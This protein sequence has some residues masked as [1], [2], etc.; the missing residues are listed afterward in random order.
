MIPKLKDL[1]Y[2]DKN[3]SK[4]LL[5]ANIVWDRGGNLT[6]YTEYKPILYRKDGMDKTNRKYLFDRVYLKKIA[7][8]IYDLI[9]Y[10]KEF[11]NWRVVSI[12]NGSETANKPPVFKLHHVRITRSGMYLKTPEFVTVFMA[13]QLPA[14]F[15]GYL[16]LA[17]K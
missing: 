4:V 10:T 6:G 12:K 13:G 1:K 5:D 11:K 17:K 8:D 16:M 3:I 15:M 14:S 2:G 9:I 7:G